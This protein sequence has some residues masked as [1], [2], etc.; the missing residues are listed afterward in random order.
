MRW[1]W[2][3]CLAGC[4]AHNPNASDDLAVP[5]DLA[6][7]N[8]AG[9]AANLT[10]GD[11]CE[12]DCRFSCHG[13]S[14]CDDANACDGAERCDSHFCHKGAPLADGTPCAGGVCR[15]SLCAPATCGNKT[16]DP[17]EECDDQN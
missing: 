12:A 7:A 8:D 5:D 1:L 4:T 14:E 2:V 3:A 13:D 15:G 10:A 11:G 9:D 17:G 16:V 6:S